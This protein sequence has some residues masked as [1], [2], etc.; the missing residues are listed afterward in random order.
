MAGVTQEAARYWPS[1]H[2]SPQ[3][4]EPRFLAECLTKAEEYVIC[5]LAPSFLGLFMERALEQLGWA[6]FENSAIQEGHV[7]GRSATKERA[8]SLFGTS[9]SFVAL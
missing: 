4:D 7:R 6:P 1:S 3:G 2:L 8:A 5:M 9:V